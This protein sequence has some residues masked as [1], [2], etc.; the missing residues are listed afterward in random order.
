M[1]PLVHI[2]SALSERSIL[3]P[4]EEARLE[5]YGSQMRASGKLE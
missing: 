1:H 2:A 4:Q 5:T 3:T